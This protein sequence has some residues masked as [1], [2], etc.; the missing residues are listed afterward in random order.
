[1]HWMIVSYVQTCNVA[2]AGAICTIAIGPI[3]LQ[4]WYK[5]VWYQKQPFIQVF[6]SL[7]YVWE[8]VEENKG[9]KVLMEEKRRREKSCIFPSSYASWEEKEWDREDKTINTRFSVNLPFSSLLFFP[10]L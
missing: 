7:Y 3:I 2:F 10:I 8:L 9:K 6:D 5:S 4:I 1:M